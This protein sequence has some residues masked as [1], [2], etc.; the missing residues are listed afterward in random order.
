MCLNK[1]SFDILLISFVFYVHNSL[2]KQ[3]ENSGVLLNCRSKIISTLTVQ[4]RT[5][6][7]FPDTQ[8]SKLFASDSRTLVLLI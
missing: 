6:P 3:T 7:S 5:N 1:N 8:K 4:C 2:E